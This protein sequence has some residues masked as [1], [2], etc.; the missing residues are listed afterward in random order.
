MAAFIPRGPVRADDPAYVKALAD[1]A[2][3]WANPSTFPIAD[4]LAAAPLGPFKWHHNR[5]DTGN[6]NETW[7]DLIPT[8]GSF[9]RGLV[10][11]SGSTIEEMAILEQNPLTHFTFCDID[12]HGLA[13]RL[14]NLG[15]RFPGRVDVSQLDLNF[16]EF[17]PNAYDLIVSAST[18]HHVL[19]LEHIGSQINRALTEDGWFFLHDYTGPSGFRFSP[20]Q[21]GIFETVYDRERAR[22]ADVN[23]PDPLW[24]NVD[25]TEFSPFEA[26]RSADTIGVLASALHEVDRRHTGTIL[27]L[28]MFSNIARAQ[29]PTVPRQI[30]CARLRRRPPGRPP[31]VWESLLSDQC[32]KELCLLDDVVTDAAIFPPMTTFATYR[33]KL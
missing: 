28:A 24:Q 4:A 3:F 32:V 22:R 1:E 12:D 19:N 30:W 27:S 14:M 6:E 15:A 31:L 11:G 8:K 23:L 2:A 16:V 21:K 33:K 13:R 29:W 9:R 26:V 20:P 5:R 25:D 17:E 10:L 7:Y 18:L